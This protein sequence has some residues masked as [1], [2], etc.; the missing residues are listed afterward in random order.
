MSVLLNYIAWSSETLWNTFHMSER[1]GRLVRIQSSLVQPVS[2]WF[3]VVQNPNSEHQTKMLQIHLISFHFL[4]LAIFYPC[5]NMSR[6]DYAIRCSFVYFSWFVFSK[7]SLLY[8]VC[9]DFTFTYIFV[10]ILC[11]A[12]VRYV[13]PWRRHVYIMLPTQI[14]LPTFRF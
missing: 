6:G 8:H 10:H 11:N 12:F 2:G 14:I 13:L 5:T 3:T 7:R 9:L 1:T 4:Q